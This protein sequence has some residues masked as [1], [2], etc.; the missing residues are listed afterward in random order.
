MTGVDAAAGM[1]ERAK[2][3]DPSG[4]YVQADLT[5]WE[6]DSPVDLVH[7]MEVLYYLLG[8]DLDSTLSR[9]HSAWLKPGGVLAA[10]VDFYAEH[11]EYV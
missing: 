9:I 8:D 7:S 4:Q 6:P 11:E 10:G 2:K 3:L 1:I 5:L